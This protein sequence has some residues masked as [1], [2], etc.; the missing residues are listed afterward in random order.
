M[1][2]LLFSLPLKLDFMSLLSEFI[3]T[4]VE[5]GESSVLFPSLLSEFIATDVETGESSVLFPS[6]L[7]ELFTPDL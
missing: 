6:L 3:A 2:H 1:Q 5:S 4:D 7:S